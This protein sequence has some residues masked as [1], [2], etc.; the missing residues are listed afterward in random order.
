VFHGTTDDIHKKLGKGESLLQLEDSYFKQGFLINPDISRTSARNGDPDI[1]SVDDE[2]GDVLFYYIETSPELF[3]VDTEIRT[4]GLGLRINELYNINKVEE[5]KK[6]EEK[7]ETPEEKFR[8]E[9]PELTQII[10]MGMA[11]GLDYEFDMDSAEEAI[12]WYNKTLKE[13]IKNKI[14]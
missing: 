7:I 3:T 9:C 12:A 10:E 8:R 1:L 4:S 13:G 11:Q 6:E 14:K 5:K 2:N